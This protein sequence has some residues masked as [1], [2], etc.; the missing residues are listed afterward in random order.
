MFYIGVLVQ[1]NSNL[2]ITA[3]TEEEWYELSTN[4]CFES[5]SAEDQCM[6]KK[7]TFS[8]VQEYKSYSHS[9]PLFL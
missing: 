6:K 4:C 8:H 5:L 1:Y 7:K 2:V 9:L 3:Q